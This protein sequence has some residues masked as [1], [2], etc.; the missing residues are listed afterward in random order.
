[1]QSVVDA[2]NKI[3]W[4]FTIDDI[5][6]AADRIRQVIESDQ[7]AA[8]VGA[9]FKK[10]YHTHDFQSA[11]NVMKLKRPFDG[12]DEFVCAAAI[13]SIGHYENEDVMKVLRIV[14]GED[15]GSA[16]PSLRPP[17]MKNYCPR[18]YSNKM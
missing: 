11:S 1:M 14:Y 10:L 13:F 17:W 8:L 16:E 9:E 7:T 5:D 15:D 12:C 6:V 3:I 18:T 2:I 4:D